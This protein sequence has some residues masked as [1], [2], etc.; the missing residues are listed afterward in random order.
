[1]CHYV[2]AFLLLARGAAVTA[3][4]TDAA[5]EICL[6]A[7]AARQEIHSGHCIIKGTHQGYFL[8]QIGEPSP[9]RIEIWFDNAH[10]RF[11]CVA[12]RRVFATG[13]TKT[14][15]VDD[16]E[17]FFV[18]NGVGLVEWRH[19]DHRRKYWKHRNGLF[20]PR[21]VGL[22]WPNEPFGQML[23]DID[24]NHLVFPQTTVH[25]SDD[26]KISIE[27]ITDR[28]WKRVL[29]L[30]SN[31]GLVPVSYSSWRAAEGKEELTW[32]DKPLTYSET[33]WTSIDDVWVPKHWK[34]KGH[35]G[36]VDSV[37]YEFE[38]VSVNQPLDPSLFSH[39]AA[40]M[41]EPDQLVYIV[42][43]TESFMAGN[44]RYTLIRPE[45]PVGQM[46]AIVIAVN[47]LT[48]AGLFVW[49]RRGMSLHTPERS[50]TISSATTSAV[51]S[52]SSST[53]SQS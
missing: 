19:K 28:T 8:S 26:G 51:K 1:M 50:V 14:I 10:Q 23:E 3:S 18:N 2:V 43:D 31:R 4:E 12:P 20:D 7:I 5:R 39:Q 40:V 47:V 35:G 52:V 15:Y 21:G 25:R 6:K 36:P 53:S 9:A 13:L 44:A 29:V 37:D 41:K 32:G 46:H 45:D 38:W 24:I 16:G 30:D 42:G 17:F 49:W 22:Y 27:T 33:E 11:R 34:V 48:L